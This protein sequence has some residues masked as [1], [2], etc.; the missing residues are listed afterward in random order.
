MSLGQSPVEGFDGRQTRRLTEEE[1]PSILVHTSCA[2]LNGVRPSSMVLQPQRLAEGGGAGG[3][4][5]G[6]GGDVGSGGDG[7][8]DG[9]SGGDGGKKLMTSP[10]GKAFCTAAAHAVLPS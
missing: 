5:D 3:G 10:M 1:T 8:G 7:G 9:G 6:A 4:G 2:R